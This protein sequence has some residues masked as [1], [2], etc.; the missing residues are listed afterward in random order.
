MHY[1]AH[2]A[3]VGEFGSLS[4]MLW[5]LLVPLQPP[6][7]S[8]SQL[9]SVSVGEL[10]VVLVA[11]HGGQSA[12]PGVPERTGTDPRTGRKAGQFETVL[13]SQT[14]ELTE[15]IFDAFHA[16]TG[17]RPYVVVARFARRFIDANRPLE[18]A[19]EH[20]GAE[21]FYRA[22]HL[23]IRQSVDH[24]RA[25]FGGGRLFDIHGQGS[26]REVVYRGT[27]S[28]L[29]LKA[30]LEMHG[31]AALTGPQGLQTQLESKGWIFIPA[32]SDS[33]RETKFNGG[34]IVQTY[35]SHQPGGIDAIQLEFGMNYRRAADRK[36][37]AEAL[38]E[39]TSRW[40]EIFPI[41]K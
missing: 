39:V 13:D 22:F 20:P 37:T 41:K 15:A 26:N 35:G 9:V 36:K 21:P 23:A 19:L 7:P 30:L 14:A 1:V 27:R 25:K 32:A 2:G 17:K 16:R 29:T 10:P 28:R 31:E 18:D 6:L 34:Y 33:S 40:L 12:V 8:S 24:A 4:S 5:A 38:A 11:S 3:Q